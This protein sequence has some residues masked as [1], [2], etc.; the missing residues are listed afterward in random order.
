[1]R[2]EE[3]RRRRPRGT[4]RR[5]ARPRRAG[6]PATATAAARSARRRGTARPSRP[7]APS[8][9]AGGRRAP[10]C[11]TRTR[12]RTGGGT[13]ASTMPTSPATSNAAQSRVAMRPT[14]RLPADQLRG[15]RARPGSSPSA[16]ARGGSAR[17]RR[18]R[19]RWRD[20]RSGRATRGRPS[21]PRGGS[22][23]DVSLCAGEV[24]PPVSPATRGHSR[25]PTRRIGP[26]GDRPVIS[27]VMS[28]DWLYG[29]SPGG[30]HDR[31]PVRRIPTPPARCRGNPRPDETRVMP[32]VP[33]TQDSADAAHR[34]SRLPGLPATTPRSTAALGRARPPAGS[35]A[36]YAAGSAGSGRP[37]FKL[38]YLWLLLALWLVYLVAVPFFAWS[39]VTK[40]NAFPAGKR[41]A[42]QAGTNY[43]LVGSDSRKGL[44]AEQRKHLHTGNDVRP[45]HRHDHAH[46]RRL[47]PTLLMSIPRDSLVADPG[48][49]HHQ[50]QRRVRLRRP[51]AADPDRRETSPASTSTTTSRSAS[52]AS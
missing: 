34:P 6:G 15:A 13:A 1:M 28:D 47:G 33:R 20:R 3:Q 35:S 8:G 38:R 4:G 31:R 7:P 27:P 43:L 14:R 36:T 18:G 24:A 23:M 17:A 45:A 48:S 40:V 30:K 2:A 51:E 44:T 37:R 32:T 25:G 19:R 41:P 11:R 39:K 42:D 49:R 46:A 9:R 21:D 10:S 16:S 22:P 12:T 52:A 26:I 50:D 5:S 29:G